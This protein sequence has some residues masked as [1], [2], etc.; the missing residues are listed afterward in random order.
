MLHHPGPYFRI[1]RAVES[2]FFSALAGILVGTTMRLPPAIETVVEEI[3][4]SFLDF[5][6]VLAK[7]TALPNEFAD[8]LAPGEDFCHAAATLDSSFS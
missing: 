6:V 3:N 4:L 7:A 1:C 2:F 5:F 8:T